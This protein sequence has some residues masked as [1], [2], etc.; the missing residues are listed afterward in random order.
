LVSGS[1]YLNIFTIIDKYSAIG[2]DL[3]RIV[4]AESSRW[5]HA[6]NQKLLALDDPLDDEKALQLQLVSQGQYGVFIGKVLI[7]IHTD[8]AAADAHYQRLRN[9]QAEG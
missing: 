6:P 9:Q 8:Q 4:Y 7:P 2:L 5:F 1:D 3:C